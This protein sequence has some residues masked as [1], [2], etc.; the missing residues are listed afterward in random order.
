MKTAQ[1]D[2]HLETLEGFYIYKASKKKPILNERY[3]AGANMIFT[4]SI[5]RDKTK[6]SNK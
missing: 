3:A 2:R 5:N 4:L 1:K 6:C